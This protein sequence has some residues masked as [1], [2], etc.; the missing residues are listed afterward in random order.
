MGKKLILMIMLVALVAT[1]MLFA[2]GE[3]EMADF[4]PAA[5]IKAPP[6]KTLI[7]LPVDQVAEKQIRIATIMVQNNPF[8]MAV[9]EGTLFAKEILK[10]RNCKVDWISV[11]DFDPQKFESAMQNVITAQYD[12]VTMFGLSEALQPVTDKAME[13]GIKVYSFNTEPGLKSKRIAFWGQDGFWGG[14][15]LG[16]ALMDEVGGSGKYAIITGS[17]NV[18]GHELRRTG[19]RD[20]LDKNS[21]MILVGEFENQDKAE[22]AYNITQ[23]LL[24]SNPDIAAIYVT[25]GGPFGAAKAIQDAGLTGKVKLICHDWMAETIEYIRSGEVSVCLDQD[26]FNQ[27]YAPVIAA[28]N[29][30]M[31]GKAPA[32]EINWFEGDIATPANVAE[33]IPE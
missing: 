22:E 18:L 2:G 24:T 33:K 12:A 17:F 8:G 31:T 6:A 19:A 1:G 25:A 28:F 4:T 29:H 14:Q 13:A 30:I 9:M 23:N 16:K 21:N 5:E 11:P 32:N 3:Q 26:P 7:G 15:T 27:G 20:V 10:D